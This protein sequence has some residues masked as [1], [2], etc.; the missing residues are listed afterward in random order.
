[1]TEVSAY[2]CVKIIV[3]L[4][5]PWST[6]NYNG[7]D[8]TTS[9]A[10]KTLYVSKLLETTDYNFGFEYLRAGNTIG[11]HAARFLEGGS[12]KRWIDLWDIVDYI[13]LDFPVTKPRGPHAHS[14]SR[15]VVYHVLPR[16]N[17]GL[18]LKLFHVIFDRDL[19]IVQVLN[20]ALNEVP[21]F[22]LPER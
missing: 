5:H 14:E 11:G 3:H 16:L 7:Q 13:L 18:V 17:L 4:Y 9:T 22:N 15:S 21:Q 2:C 12:Y 10:G 6:L 8:D 19:R 1:M 20:S